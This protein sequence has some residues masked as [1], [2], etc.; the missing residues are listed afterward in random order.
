MA[1]PF[2]MRQLHQFA[3]MA[4]PLAGALLLCPFAAQAQLS[5]EPY[6]AGEIA[7][8]SNLIRLEDKDAAEAAT[9]DRQLADTYTK[10][11]AGL[12]A[13]YLYSLQRF[14]VSGET[15]KYSYDNNLGSDNT[16]YEFNGGVEGTLWRLAEST[17]DYRY[18]RRLAPFEYRGDGQTVEETDKIASAE[19]N[20]EV[21]PDWQLEGRFA[22]RRYDAPQIE[23]PEFGLKERTYYGGIGYLGIAAVRFSIGQEWVEGDYSG[24]PI[25][26][27]FD[28]TSTL[29]K[30]NYVA[31][32]FSEF[33][34]E[35]GYTERDTTGE[36]PGSFSGYTGLLSYQRQISGKTRIDG[37]IYRR[38]DSYE[39][40]AEYVIDSGARIAAAWQAT[41]KVGLTG[42]ADYSNRNYQ[43]SGAIVDPTGADR[44]DDEIQLGVEANWQAL[45]W[46]TISPRVEYNTRSSNEANADFDAFLYAVQFEGRL[47]LPRR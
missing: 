4:P 19:L 16:A 31:S 23:K 46:L 26:T 29:V 33:V 43:E 32:G 6:V 35:F 2:R 17:L 41:G 11:S 47:Y 22:D 1:G 25:E 39:A 30:L 7:H 40:S 24:E 20:L 27:T 10:L 14:Y 34:L 3:R 38:V 21:T 18:R 42:Y 44:K 8:D 37:S 15:S 13:E 12:D 36:T 45:R 5:Y 9:G 28:E